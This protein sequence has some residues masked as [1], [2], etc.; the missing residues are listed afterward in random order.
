MV[1]VVLVSSVVV[2][3]V[4]CCLLVA[5]HILCHVSQLLYS[6]HFRFAQHGIPRVPD[7]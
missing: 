5:S 1:A 6:L 3:F 7:S 4:C 2:L